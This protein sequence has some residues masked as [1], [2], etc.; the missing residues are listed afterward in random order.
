MSSEGSAYVS[1]KAQ[2]HKR[3]GRRKPWQKKQ[4]RPCTAK[5]EQSQIS[6][7]YLLEDTLPAT[8]SLSAQKTVAGFLVSLRPLFTGSYLQLSRIP[9]AW[10][11][12]QVQE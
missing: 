11:L 5:K 8:P 12:G 6:S 2:L 10:N 4:C 1:T 3:R 9:E 7:S